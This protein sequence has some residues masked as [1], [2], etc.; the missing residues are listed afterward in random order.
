MRENTNSKIG[1]I[2]ILSLGLTTVIGSGVWGDPFS[3]VN[4]AGSYSILVIVISWM[5]FFTAGLAYAEVVGMFPKS[6]GPYSYVSG[7]IN[8]KWGSILGFVYYFG[9]TIIGAILVFVS[10]SSFLEMIGVDSFA[11]LII[12]TV[13]VIIILAFVVEAIPLRI[14]GWTI[15][16]WICLKVLSL[17]IISLFFI[18]KGNGANLNTSTF[19]GEMFISIGNSSLWA[20]MGF[21]VLLVFSGDLKLKKG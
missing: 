18:I 3:W 12:L 7:A 15:S 10:V 21:E 20:L 14:I 13:L 19:T 4:T 2:G 11:L 6:G 16:I 17:L 5:L 8:K 1:I 9:Y